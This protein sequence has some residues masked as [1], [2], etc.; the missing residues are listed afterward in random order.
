MGDGECSIIFQ[1][2]L[3]LFSGPKSPACDFTSVSSWFKPSFPFGETGRL[4]AATVR[5]PAGIRL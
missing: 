2:N 5:T 1:L 4:E 3:N